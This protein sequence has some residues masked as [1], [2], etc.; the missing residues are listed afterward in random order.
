M[1]NDLPGLDNGGEVLPRGLF[2]Y[3][4]TD[5]AR[6][7]AKLKDQD[8]LDDAVWSREVQRLSIDLGRFTE[9]QKTLAD[10][11][12]HMR[13]EK[14]RLE[15]QV[16]Q[17]R[18]A[19]R[20]AEDGVRQEIDRQQM[21]H[22]R[23]LAAI[24]AAQTHADLEAQAYERQLW[25]LAENLTRVLQ[26]SQNL[27]NQQLSNDSPDSVWDQ[28]MRT[29][30][31]E[32]MAPSVPEVVAEL[33]ERRRVPPDLVQVSTRQGDRLGYLD[34]VLLSIVPPAIVAYQVQGR[35]LIAAHDVQVLRPRHITVQARFAVIDES[36]LIAMYS[37]PRHRESWGSN[38]ATAESSPA[39][40][41]AHPTAPPQH[42]PNVSPLPAPE[43]VILDNAE[44]PDDLSR[45]ATPSPSAGP[46]IV[47]TGEFKLPDET[48]PPS[49]AETV[50]A[51][52]APAARGGDPTLDAA[53]PIESA[54]RAETPSAIPDDPDHLP[55]DHAERPPALPA[56]PT[57]EEPPAMQTSD[58]PANRL[59]RNAPINEATGSGPLPSPKPTAGHDPTIPEPLWVLSVPVTETA[60]THSLALPGVTE[61]NPP[62]LLASSM[63]DRTES[64]LGE[65][66]LP[67]LTQR[68]TLLPPAWTDGGGGPPRAPFQSQQ[69]PSSASVPLVD[70]HDSDSLTAEDTG[71]IDVR[72]FLY[73]KRVGREIRDSSGRV[74]A[75]T[76]S[77]I[78]PELLERVERA[79]FLPDLIVH[80]VF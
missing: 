58:D 6:T 71:A 28:F 72:R 78:T 52:S 56:T 59:Q 75:P 34:S 54:V 12:E 45:E 4:I 65:D 60:G 20:Y 1:A 8:A 47:D 37:T 16:R 11:V 19:S 63:V 23:R 69:S 77:E 80:M 39:G 9:R 38:S 18:I 62:I 44:N 42:S 70:N 30:L 22:E 31:G 32:G 53:Y 68:S 27:A 57:R 66:S 79:G 33:L 13:Q 10:L 5:V 46:D 25:Q 26:D 55:V 50:F 24:H 2:G 73:G 35:G 29:V 74:L 40:L 51:E 76:G 61:Q 7:I 36:R 64:Q 49:A 15:D 3:R 67:G 14:L 21:E 17:A 41:L 43:T 48:S